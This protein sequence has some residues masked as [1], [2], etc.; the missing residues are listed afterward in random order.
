MRDNS[1]KRGFNR[2]LI[3][4]QIG[5]ANTKSRNDTLTYTTHET[6]K[7]I[8]LTT[9]FNPILSQINNTLKSDWNILQIKTWGQRILSRT[10]HNII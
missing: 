8:P 4:H 2:S 7:R 1:I 3:T 10:T 9:T 6:N 5:K